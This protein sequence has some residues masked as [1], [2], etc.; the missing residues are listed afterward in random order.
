MRNPSFADSWWP[1]PC[2]QADAALENRD[3][4]LQSG[5]ATRRE[6]VRR[7]LELIAD[8]SEIVAIHDGARP[9]VS[10]ELIDRAV[11]AARVKG[12]V[13]VGLPA[14]PRENNF[15]LLMASDGVRSA[16][17]LVALGTG[18]GRLIPLTNSAW[19]L[20]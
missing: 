5:G 15:P 4:V 13:A 10:P 9:F 19:A 6:S 11:E 3:W 12:A 17:S 1:L 18:G 20:R 8:D 2:D 14:L 16:G 7:G